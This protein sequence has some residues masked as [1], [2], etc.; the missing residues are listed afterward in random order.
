MLRPYLRRFHPHTCN[1]TRRISSTKPRTRRTRRAAA[2][3][4]WISSWTTS[5]CRWESGSRCSAWGAVGS[6]GG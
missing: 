1:S 5:T 4:P 6:R 2:F 3:R